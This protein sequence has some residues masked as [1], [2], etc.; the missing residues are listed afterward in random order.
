MLR[1]NGKV[2]TNV[3]DRFVSLY[4]KAALPRMSMKYVQNF[5]LGYLGES[6]P[7]LKCTE[8]DY[9]DKKLDNLCCPNDKYK[10]IESIYSIF[11]VAVAVVI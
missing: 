10:K 5:Y 6:F 9:S 7:D 1:E 11:L 3:D 4:E 8:V 2:Y